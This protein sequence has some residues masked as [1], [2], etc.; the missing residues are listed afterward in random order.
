MAQYIVIPPNLT[1]P[2]PTVFERTE[3]LF[4]RSEDSSFHSSSSDSELSTIDDTNAAVII[5]TQK[6]QKVAAQRPQQQ[7]PQQQSHKK[8][9]IS[10]SLRFLRNKVDQ[11]TEVD[12]SV[13]RMVQLRAHIGLFSCFD[14]DDTETLTTQI[15]KSKQ[16]VS[17]LT[18]EVRASVGQDAAQWVTMQ[19]MLKKREHALSEAQQNGIMMES[20]PS[21][22]VLLQKQVQL[23]KLLMDTENTVCI[24]PNR[25]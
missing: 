19:R 8:Q 4:K 14:E 2:L 23:Q 7:R 16:I 3:V 25:D 15:Q 18:E 13:Y 11:I 21:F 22:P 20:D 24:A 5:Q 12:Q 1:M 6:D 10:P 17:A 9:Q